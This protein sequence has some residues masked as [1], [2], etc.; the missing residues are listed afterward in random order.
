ML[1]FIWYCIFVY[2]CSFYFSVKRPTTNKQINNKPDISYTC[3]PLSTKV[4]LI[5]Y[6]VLQPIVW[7][8]YLGFL[9]KFLCHNNSLFLSLSHHNAKLSSA[10]YDAQI[11]NNF[12]FFNV[13]VRK[14]VGMFHDFCHQTLFKI[15]TEYQFKIS[16][17]TRIIWRLQ[18]FTQK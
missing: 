11:Y 15:V 8:I 1:N 17:Y 6:I 2:C 10:S 9:S 16:Q 3:T 4:L 12:L 14:S 5:W 18:R 7:L 13:S